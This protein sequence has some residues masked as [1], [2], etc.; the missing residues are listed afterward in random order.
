MKFLNAWRATACEIRLSRKG[1]WSDIYHGADSLEP[2]RFIIYMLV[3]GVLKS[4]STLGRSIKQSP[5]VFSSIY[6]WRDGIGAGYPLVAVP[7]SDK[8]AGWFGGDACSF[9]PQEVVRI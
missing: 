8:L 1:P 5:K 6:S 3:G 9:I 7:R 2:K 4:A